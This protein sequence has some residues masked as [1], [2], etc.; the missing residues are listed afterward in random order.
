MLG[1]R[2]ADR[3]FGGT[4]LAFMFGNGGNDQ[5][6]RSDGTLFESLDGGLSG[7][8]WKDFA[9]ESGRVWYVAGTE[10]DDVI[11]VDFVNEPGLLG[12]HHLITRPTSTST[13][14][15]PTRAA[16]RCGIRRTWC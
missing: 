3:L 4:G 6:F 8:D 12:D 7:N 10:A 14:T 5:M 15:P 9:K 11:T 16:T 1:S 13:S 2:N